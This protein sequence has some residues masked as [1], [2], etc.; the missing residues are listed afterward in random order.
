MQELESGRMNGI[1]AEVAVEIGVF[2]Q[3]NDLHSGAREEIAGHHARRSAAD[4]EAPDVDIREHVQ[5]LLN[6]RIID[7]V[8]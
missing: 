2:F 1:A 7:E 8:C 3:N 6:C 5:R 4:N